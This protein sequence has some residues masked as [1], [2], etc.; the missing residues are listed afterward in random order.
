MG[1][2]MALQ[3]P[4][5]KTLGMA[6]LVSPI[7]ML[8]IVLFAREY[9]FIM[10]PHVHVGFQW[11]VYGNYT[12]IYIYPVIKMLVVILFFMSFFPTNLHAFCILVC[13][14]Q[15]LLYVYI[16]NYPECLFFIFLFCSAR[17]TSKMAL[18]KGMLS[19][20]L[21]AEIVRGKDRPK[22]SFTISIGMP[23]YFTQ[24][25][26]NFIIMYFRSIN[27]FNIIRLSR[28]NTSNQPYDQTRR[29]SRRGKGLFFRIGKKSK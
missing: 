5:H 20:E 6:S 14:Y 4:P 9:P 8:P 25:N 27:I 13:L 26:N 28:S 3:P 7:I 16:L 24:F 10:K 12:Y 29:R 2:S 15:L 21:V 17:M 23:I 1:V 22:S 19:K 18:R 11:N